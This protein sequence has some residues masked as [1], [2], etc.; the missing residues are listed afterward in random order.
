MSAY[1][2]CSLTASRFQGLNSSS[3]RRTRGSSNSLPGTH[4]SGKK[5]KGLAIPSFWAQF[6]VGPGLTS[7][8]RSLD[9]TVSVQNSL[10]AATVRAWTLSKFRQIILDCYI[11]KLKM[12]SDASAPATQ[13]TPFVCEFFFNKYGVK[14]LVQVSGHMPV[15]LCSCTM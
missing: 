15:S 5:H 10:G 12:D 4:R 9:L 8:S 14:R 2:H 13:L 11:E 7:H 1:N 6:M 3:S